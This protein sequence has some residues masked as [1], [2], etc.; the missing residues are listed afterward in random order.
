MKSGTR[1]LVIEIAS[2]FRPKLPKRSRIFVNPDGLGTKPDQMTD[3]AASPA[4]LWLVS[5]N[6]G[7]VNESGSQAKNVSKPLMVPG[8]SRV[9]VDH[10]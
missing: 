10:N 3:Q 9:A 1:S 4:P 2:T 8:P 5:Y 6:A 7:K